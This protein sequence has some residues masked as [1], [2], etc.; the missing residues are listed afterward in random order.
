MWQAELQVLHDVPCRGCITP[1]STL[2]L[3]LELA[4]W[5]C[6]MQGLIDAHVHM[7]FG[8]LTLQ[9]IDLRYVTSKAAF[10]SEVQKAAGESNV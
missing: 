4:L 9:Q 6:H 5:A 3:V 8:G 2:S 7:I 1:A 10:I